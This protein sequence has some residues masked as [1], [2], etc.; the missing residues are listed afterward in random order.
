MQVSSA[1][2]QPPQRP[3]AFQVKQGAASCFEFVSFRD[4]HTQMQSPNI[5]QRY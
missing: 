1:R 3:P 2:P 5:V 4:I